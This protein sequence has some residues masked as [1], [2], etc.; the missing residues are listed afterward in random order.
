MVNGD[1]EF[2]DYVIPCDC[3][4]MDHDIRIK[5]MSFC[6]HREYFQIIVKIPMYIEKDN[7]IKRFVNIFKKKLNFKIQ[8][9]FYPEHIPMINNILVFF[10]NDF[11]IIQEWEDGNPNTHVIDGTILLNNSI[12][13]S[14]K[15][16]WEY[17]RYGYHDGYYEFFMDNDDVYMYDDFNPET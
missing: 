12:K 8:T 16:I 6:S 13:K 9:A 5:Y 4:G 10:N 1:R 7:I 14:F 17:L 2:I 15:S 11:K 3:G